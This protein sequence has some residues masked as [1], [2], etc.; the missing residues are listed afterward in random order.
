M[1]TYPIHSERIKRVTGKERHGM[2]IQETRK[3]D[4]KNK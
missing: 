1:I 3:G 2:V 4:R